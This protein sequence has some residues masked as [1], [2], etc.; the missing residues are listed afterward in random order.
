MERPQFMDDGERELDDD[1]SGD[2]ATFCEDLDDNVI[3]DDDGDD[4]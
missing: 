4:S 3:E 2:D 1:E